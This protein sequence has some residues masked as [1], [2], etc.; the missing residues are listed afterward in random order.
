MIVVKFW[1]WRA[2]PGANVLEQ[3]N[4]Y[5]RLANEANLQNVC[6]D[7]SSWSSL[8]T[9]EHLFNLKVPISSDLKRDVII[10]NDVDIAHPTMI[11]QYLAGQRM[12]GYDKKFTVLKSSEPH[13]LAIEDSTAE[14]KCDENPDLGMVCVVADDDMG[15]YQALIDKDYSVEDQV[16]IG[17]HVTQSVGTRRKAVSRRSSV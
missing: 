7:Y 10:A 3:I 16:N 11:E 15:A 12:S 8:T 14:K 6:F 9:S 1:N 13:V 5:I 2:A 4:I 17:C